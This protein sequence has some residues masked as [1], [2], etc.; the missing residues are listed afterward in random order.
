VELQLRAIAQPTRREILGLITQAELTSGEIAAQFDLTQ[1]A[2][3]Q[4]LKVL[5]EAGLA[6]VRKE[7]TRRLYRIR[8]EGL[9]DLR[10]FIEQM[11]EEALNRLKQAA[12]AQQHE[13]SRGEYRQP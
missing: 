6:L 12:E 7:G 5:T 11:W 1:P 8:L 3:S 13:H 10:E 4:H 2:I 9:V